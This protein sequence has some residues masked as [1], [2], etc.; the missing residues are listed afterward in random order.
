MNVFPEDFNARKVSQKCISW[1]LKRTESVPKN[2]FPE[3]LNAWN[4]PSDAI[5]GTLMRI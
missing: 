2:V 5:F 3:D 4:R 1:R